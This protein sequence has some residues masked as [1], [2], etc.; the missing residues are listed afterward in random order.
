MDKISSSVSLG[1]VKMSH[2]TVSVNY[3]LIYKNIFLNIIKSHDK[4][5]T[6]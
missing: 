5:F 6:C 3:L 1:H 2:V 4:N